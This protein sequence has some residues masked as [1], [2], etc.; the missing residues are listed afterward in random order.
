MAKF[1]S[2]TIQSTLLFKVVLTFEP[3]FNPA[4]GRSFVRWVTDGKKKAAKSALTSC[5]VACTLFGI[6]IEEVATLWDVGRVAH[7]EKLIY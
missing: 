4:I 3:F 5:P 2:C 7:F 1:D 6:A